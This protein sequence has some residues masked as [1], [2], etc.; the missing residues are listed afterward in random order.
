MS[1]GEGSVAVSGGI[2]RQKDVTWNTS[3]A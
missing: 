2:E 3:T 1:K